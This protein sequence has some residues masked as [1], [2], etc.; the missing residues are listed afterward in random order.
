MKLEE[1][2]FFRFVRPSRELNLRSKSIRRRLGSSC[3][4]TASTVI[5]SAL[6]YIVLRWTDTTTRRHRG[7]RVLCPRT[8]PQTQQHPPNQSRRNPRTRTK[9]GNARK[10]CSCQVNASRLSSADYHPTCLRIYSG[11]VCQTGSLMKLLPGRRT[12]L[13]SRRNGMIYTLYHRRQAVDSCR[14]NKENIPSRAYIAFKN[15]EQLLI[16]GREYDGHKF[17]DKAGTSHSGCMRTYFHLLV[18]G[19]N[20]M[21]L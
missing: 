21:P 8:L 4:V 19:T 10:R 11:R 17:V 20:R 3:I 13:E 7:P 18:Q 1:E 5:K 15:L 12:S 14:V 2:R 16:F 9:T 6:F